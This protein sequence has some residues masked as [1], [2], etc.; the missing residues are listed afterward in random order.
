MKRKGSH[1]RNQ[2]EDKTDVNNSS[3]HIILLFSKSLVL[4]SFFILINIQF[5]SENPSNYRKN[6]LK[7][8]LLI[9][10]LNNILVVVVAVRGG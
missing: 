4:S 1:F 5:L 7:L 2:Q 3:A 6:E 8:L 9:I 10:F